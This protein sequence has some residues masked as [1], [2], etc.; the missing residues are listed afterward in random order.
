MNLNAKI[1]WEIYGGLEFAILVGA[2]G[3]M[4]GDLSF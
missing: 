4:G 3:I 2:D 1:H